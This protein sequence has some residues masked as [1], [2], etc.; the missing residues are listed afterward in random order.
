M[1]EAYGFAHPDALRKAASIARARDIE[2]S[3]VGWLNAWG[4]P[5]IM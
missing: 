1:S 3:R 5:R 4:L 2:K